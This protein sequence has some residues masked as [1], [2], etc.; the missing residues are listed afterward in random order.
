MMAVIMIFFV[1]CFLF[2]LFIL[3]H[4]ELVCL[5]CHVGQGIGKTAKHKTR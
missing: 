5:N 3:T 1:V 2:L 4:Y